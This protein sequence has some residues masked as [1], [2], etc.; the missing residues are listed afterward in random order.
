MTK[1]KKDCEIPAFMAA[2]TTLR[3]DLTFEEIL[4]EQNYKPISYEK[5]RALFD[6]IEWTETLDELL[7]AL[8]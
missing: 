1:T 6:D 5:V 3:E 4:K 2:I 8:D 7:A